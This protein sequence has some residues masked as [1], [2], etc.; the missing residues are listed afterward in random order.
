MFLNI[1]ARLFLKLISMQKTTKN[2]IVTDER[3]SELMDAALKEKHTK[4]R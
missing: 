3:L 4:T 2:G 1:H